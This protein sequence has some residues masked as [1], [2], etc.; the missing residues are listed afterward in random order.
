[1]ASKSA[2]KVDGE[3]IQ[4]DTQL[5][6]Q[7]LVTAGKTDLEQALKF[8]LCTI[9]KTL[10]EAPELLHEAQKLTLMDSIWSI[11]GKKDVTLSNNVQY[12]LDGGALLH[13]IPWARGTSFTNILG[14][15]SN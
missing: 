2:L 9:P 6:F 8:E 14:S 15:Y 10:F 1:M 4:V 13:R 3:S 7:R 5:F 11:S 12:V